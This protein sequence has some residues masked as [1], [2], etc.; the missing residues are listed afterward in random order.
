MENSNIRGNRAIYRIM[1]QLLEASNDAKG[2][3]LDAELRSTLGEYYETF[4]LLKNIN[5]Q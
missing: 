5:K 2:N 3:Y 1:E 4:M